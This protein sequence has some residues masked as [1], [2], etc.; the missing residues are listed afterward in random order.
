MSL[1]K[2]FF[3]N[4]V[5][6]VSTYI[7][8]F[9]T[10]PYI[11]RV[12]GVENV[13]IIG[14]VDNIIN[15]FVLFTT[16]G[17]QTVGIREIAETNG[18]KEKCT[19]VYSQLL[20]FTILFTFISVVIYVIAVIYISTLEQYKSYLLLGIGK[21]LFMPLMIEWLFTG[22]Q[23]FKYISVRTVII[24]TLYLISIF[25][26][27]R[28]KEDLYVYFV[29]N[30][31]LFFFNSIVNLIASRKYVDYKL[32]KFNCKKYIKPIFVLGLFSIIT[33]L[34]ST[35]NYVYL[36]SVASAVQVGYYYTAIR[37]YD[38][39]MQIFRSYTSVAMPR[40][41]ELL[42]FNEKEKFEMLIMKSYNALFSYTIPLLFISV[43]L[44]PFIIRVIAGPGYDN[45]II[46]MRIIMPILII[47]G[48]NQINGIQ[49]LMPLHKDKVLLLTGSLAAFVGVLSNVLLDPIYGA[50]GAALTILFSEITGCLG[51][52]VFVL[53]NKIYPLPFKP[54][55]KYFISSLPYLLL[56]IIFDMFID[57]FYLK[58]IVLLLCFCVY[59]FVQQ[60]YI[61]Q[62]ELVIKIIGRKS[63]Y[64]YN[65]TV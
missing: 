49:V 14:Y 6:T 60:V 39:I 50:V 54:F 42:S 52:V 32:F 8:A 18:D 21:L 19:A 1:T 36:G 51:G 10:F 40:M 29:L 22:R 28:Q 62:N 37:I 34:Y 23:D 59:F 26:F 53:R 44:A 41:S 16:L 43:L 33:S 63:N 55:I 47:A 2:N 38:V 57:G 25:V 46:V 30:S 48:I 5:I 35:F 65:K 3:Y 61:C 17:V 13:G 56:Y 4:I 20:S 15:Y 24:K 58:Y 7:V 27:I 31:F 45:A 9:L 64:N 12:L 11:S